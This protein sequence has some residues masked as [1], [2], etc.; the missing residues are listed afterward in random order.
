MIAAAANIASLGLTFNNLARQ[1]SQGSSLGPSQY[2][3]V[4]V[5]LV[6]VTFLSSALFLA[7]G[8][9]AKDF[10]DG[11]NLATPVMMLTMMPAAVTMLPGVE[12]NLYTVFIPCVNV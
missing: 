2:L 9:F 5:V 3:L 4:F 11:Q 8:V 12:A 1:M 7:I 10:R 6:P